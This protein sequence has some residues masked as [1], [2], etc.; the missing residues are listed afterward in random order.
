MQDSYVSVNKDVILKLCN[1]VI[2]IVIKD[3]QRQDDV[4]IKQ[5]VERK[6]KAFF[7]RVFK[8]RVYTY[9]EVK[10]VFDWYSNNT[11]AALRDR[12]EYT[13]SFPSDYG[14]KAMEV[15]HRL[16]NATTF[17][18]GESMYVSSRDLEILEAHSR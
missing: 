16:K 17:A 2:N 11:G 12:W 18:D 6:N 9:E 3:R 13:F 4:L 8:K 1:D 7:N 14:E 15:A 10:K 5:I